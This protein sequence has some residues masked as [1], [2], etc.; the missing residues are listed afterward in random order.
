MLFPFLLLFDF[1]ISTPIFFAE[2]FAGTNLLDRHKP[3]LVDL[4]ITG[5]A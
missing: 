5:L 2:Y 1:A 4:N 3:F